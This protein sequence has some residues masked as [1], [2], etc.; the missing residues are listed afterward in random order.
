M[1]NAS[2]RPP[3]LANLEGPLANEEDVLHAFLDGLT[4]ASVAE[5]DWRKLAQLAERDGRTAELAFA[6]ETIA[7]GKRIKTYAPAL[8]AEFLYRAAVYFSTSLGDDFGARNFLERAVAI[9][10]GH[11]R[12]LRMLV[13]QLEDA[14]DLRR[15]AD[16]HLTLAKQGKSEAGASSL[17]RA[18][19]ILLEREEDAERAIAALQELVRWEPMDADARKQL[20]ELYGRAGRLKDLAKLAEQVVTTVGVEA[21]DV[22]LAREQLVALYGGP[23]REPEKA[24]PHLEAILAVDPS[25]GEALAVAEHLL[26]VRATAG[27]AAAALRSAAG[28]RGDM[29][30]QLRYLLV[31][32]EYARGAK[33]KEVLGQIGAIK[34]GHLS[35][36]RGALEAYEAA[37]L[38]DPTDDALRVHYKHI[39]SGLGAHGD[40]AKTMLRVAPSV[41][42]QDARSRIGVD[43]GELL[44]AAGDLRRAKASFS[45]ALTASTADPLTA[46]RAAIGLDTIAQAENDPKGRVAA[47]ERIVQL[48]NDPDLAEAATL[49]LAEIAGYVGDDAR[50]I[51]ANKR[52]LETGHR[53]LALASLVPL[54]DRAG[55]YAELVPILDELSREEAD[56]GAAESLAVRA[57]SLIGGELGDPEKAIS[58]WA[59]ILARF[60]PSPATLDAYEAILAAHGN[61][62]DLANV[63]ELKAVHA[64]PEGRPEVLLKL[65]R[66][67]LGTLEDDL[68]AADAYRHALESDL[69][70]TTRNELE[71]MLDST[72][73]RYLA[74][75]VLEPYYRHAENP[76]ALLRTLRIR[77]EDAA[78][79]DQRIEAAEE[80]IAMLHDDVSGAQV[81]FLRVRLRIAADV[82]DPPEIASWM[83]A[84]ESAFARK[85]DLAEARARTLANAIDVENLRPEAVDVVAA[86]ASAFEEA[87]LYGESA[88]MLRYLLPLEARLPRAHLGGPDLL[89][90]IDGLLQ[91]HGG[92]PERIAVYREALERES[93]LQGKLRLLRT[94]A[95]IEQYE[96]RDAKRASTTLEEAFELAPQDD[97][98]YAMLRDLYVSVSADRS[99]AHL[100][101]R[102]LVQGTELQQRDAHRELALVSVR[103]GKPDEASAHLGALLDYPNLDAEELTAAETVSS[104]IE[105]PGLRQR[106]L[107][108]RIEAASPGERAM[109]RV[110]LGASYLRTG[111][112]EL[113][114]RSL[115]NALSEALETDSDP[116]AITAAEA[117]L[118]IEA[119]DDATA[120]TLALLY[121]RNG[122][123]ARAVPLLEGV[124]ERATDPEAIADRD[125]E[126]SELFEEELG[127]LGKAFEASKRA[128]QGSP[129]RP[130]ALA[131]FERLAMQA[132]A[133]NDFA[134]TVEAHAPSVDREL[135]LGARY[136]LSRAR[137]LA[138]IDSDR[139]RARETLKAFLSHAEAERSEPVLEA[140]SLFE[141]L[142]A[143]LHEVDDDAAR[144]ELRWLKQ[145]RIDRK[146]GAAKLELLLDWA[147][148]EES[149]AEHA[150]ALG[151]YGQVL[152][153]YPAHLDALA[154]AART[155]LA[156]G[157]LDRALEC[158]GALRAAADDTVLLPLR[159]FEHALARALLEGRGA[160]GDVLTIAR[161][162]LAADPT[163]DDAFALLRVLS[164]GD[165]W[166]K[167]VLAI[168]E[169]ARASLSA[170][171]D[172]RF[173]ARAQALRT[174]C[175]TIIDLDKTLDA[176]RRKA[177]WEELLV[178]A[179][180]DEEALPIA[181]EA[182]HADPSDERLWDRI[183]DL[184]S[185]LRTPDPVAEAYHA[186]LRAESSRD[187]LALLGERAVRFYEE[188]YEEA[189]KREPL[190]ELLFERLPDE[191]WVFE[192]LKLL[193][194]AEERWSELFSI[195]DRAI[196]RA[197]GDA[198]LALLEDAAHTA[199][200]FAKD[201]P[202]AIAYFEELDRRK[203]GSTKTEGALERLYERHGRNAELVTLLVRQRDRATDADKVLGL[204]LRAADV[205]LAS[206]DLARASEVLA[207][208]AT[209]LHDDVR[210]RLETILTFSDSNTT[211]PLEVDEGSAR[212]RT[213]ARVRISV[214]RWLSAHYASNKDVVG[215]LARVL[216]VELRES[217]PDDATASD[218][219][220]HERL[221]RLYEQ[222]GAFESAL[223]HRV[224]LLLLDPTSDDYRSA[225]E[226]V[227]DRLEKQATYADALEQAAALDISIDV[228][229]RYL[230][231]A[232]KTY[233]A[234]GSDRATE[235]GLRVARNVEVDPAQR[236]EACV[237]IEAA[238]QQHQQQGGHSEVLLELL[239]LDASL[240][241]DGSRRLEVLSKAALLAEQRKEWAR[242]ASSWELRLAARP[243]DRE[244]LEHLA[245]LYERLEQAADLVRIL[246]L[247]LSL[248]L[249]DKAAQRRDAERAA[250][251]LEAPLGEHRRALALW[252]SIE[253][254]F[255][256]TFESAR[257]LARLYARDEDGAAY[258][259]AMQR[260][261]AAANGGGADEGN[262]ERAD[263]LSE[264]AVAE[265]TWANKRAN[266]LAHF[267]KALDISPAQPTARKWLHSLLEDAELR[268]G[269]LALLLRSHRTLGEN[270]EVLAL[271]EHR[272]AVAQSDDDKF[273]IFCDAMVLAEAYGDDQPEALVYA[274]R[275]LFLAPWHED[276]ERELLRLAAS[277]NALAEASQTLDTIIKTR[278]GLTD[279]ED[280]P[281]RMRVS[282]GNVLLDH[283]DAAG[284]AF[285]SFEKAYAD[286]PQLR[287]AAT[288]LLRAAAARNRY[289][290]VVD[291]LMRWQGDDGALDR[292]LLALAETAV[293]DRKELATA[294]ASVL[295][296]QNALDDARA[297]ALSLAT[298][299][300][301]ELASATVDAESLLER[302]IERSPPHVEIL[303]S[304][305][306]RL[307]RERPS[308]KLVEGLWA[309][310]HLKGGS[311]DLLQ[312]AV[313]AS[314]ALGDPDL[315]ILSLDHA[316]EGGKALDQRGDQGAP[317]LRW[318]RL[319]AA[320]TLEA[321]EDWH[322]LGSMLAMH[323]ELPYAAAERQELLLAASRVFLEHA[324]DADR[325][326]GLLLPEFQADPTNSAVRDRLTTLYETQGMGRA[327]VALLDR[328]IAHTDAISERALLRLKL[329]RTSEDL[330][331]WETSVGTLRATLAEDRSHGGTVAELARVL[332]ANARA[333]ELEEL[334]YAQSE[335]ARE[336]ARLD[337]AAAHLEHAADVAY[338]LLEDAPLALR[339]LERAIQFEVTEK[340]CDRVA[341]LAIE[342]GQPLVAIRY[343]QTLLGIVEGPARVPYLV[344][345]A[346][347]HA[348]VGAEQDAIGALE[349]ALWI[350]PGAK[351]ARSRIITLCRARGDA[352]RLAPLLYDAVAFADDD[353]EKVALL[354]E[355]ADLYAAKLDQAARAAELLERATQLAPE[356]RSLAMMLADALGQSG[357]RDGAL[358]ILAQLAS[359][360]GTRRPKERAPVHYYLARLHLHAGRDD[361]AFAEIETATRIDPTHLPA[362]SMLASIAKTMG[363]LDRAERAYR[364]V[365]NLLRRTSSEATP[366]TTY[367]C[368]VL[369][370][371]SDIARAQGENERA[372]EILETAFEAAAD[373]SFE[374]DQ[375]ERRFRS[376]GDTAL[377][378]RALRQRT[379]RGDPHGQAAHELATLLASESPTAAWQ[380]ALAALDRSPTVVAFHDSARA[381]AESQDRIQDLRTELHR[382]ADRA[383]RG[384]DTAT[385]A[386]LLARAA[387]I[388]ALHDPTTAAATLERARDLGLPPADV[389]PALANAYARLGVPEKHADILEA[390]L[391]VATD[392]AQKRELLRL[393]AEL[394]AKKAETL[395][396]AADHLAEVAKL[397][398]EDAALR[399]LRD[400]TD[401]F[402]DHAR[403][404]SQYDELARSHG[405]I[406]D[407]VDALGKLWSLD[408]SSFAPLEE[409]FELSKDAAPAL[410]EQLLRRCLE[411]GPSEATR[412]R[413]WAL[414]KLSELRASAGDISGSL[415]LLRDAARSEDP[416][417]ARAL[418][419][420]LG[421][422]ATAA[423]NLVLAVETYET[424]R[425]MDASDPEIWQPLAALYRTTQQRAKLLALLESVTPDIVA[426][427]ARAAL[428]LERVQ[429]L[430]AAGETS[431]DDLAAALEAVLEDDP[432]SAEAVQELSALYMKRSGSAGMF[433]F[434]E[435]QI[436]S[437][438]LRRD[439]T[440]VGRFAKQLA[441]GHIN[442]KNA[443][444]AARVLRDASEIATEDKDLLRL[445]LQCLVGVEGGERALVL[446]R[447]L[448]METGNAAADLSLELAQMREAEWDAA[449]AERALEIGFRAAP[450]NAQ[451][452]AKLET[453][454]RERGA[455]FKL[456]ELFVSASATEDSDDEK[457]DMLR[458]AATT[459]SELAGEPKRAAAVLKQAR[460]FRPMDL[461]LLEEHV[462]AL[463]AADDAAQAIAELSELM[464]SGDL[465]E[466]DRLVLVGR[467]A[468]LRAMC[469]QEAEAMDD[470]EAASTAGSSIETIADLAELAERLAMHAMDQGDSVAWRR[471]RLKGASLAE[472]VGDPDRARSA[473]EDLL[474]R[475]S[476]DEAVLFA[477][478][479]LE[480]RTEAWISALATYDRL[481][482]NLD[483]EA[484][485][486]VAIRIADLADRTEQG[487]YARDVLERAAASNP[488]R[489]D[490]HERL[491]QHYEGAGEWAYAAR[492]TTHLA[493][494]T[495]DVTEK[496][497]F[498]Q[499]SGAYLLDGGGTADEALVP[500]EEALAFA[501]T[502][503]DVVC[504]LADAYTMADR[505]ND[506]GALLQ[507]TIAAQKGRRTRELGALHH[508]MARVAQAAG[509]GAQEL[510]ALST[511]L[512]MDPQNGTAAAELAQLALDTGNFEVASRALRAVTLLKQPGPMSRAQAYEYLGEIAYQQGDPKKAMVMLKRALDEEPHLERAQALLAALR[513]K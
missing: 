419:E 167:D 77:A 38:L 189:Q 188:W 289:P 284:R 459:Y 31:E 172:D 350:S 148:D 80:G 473:L 58:A 271:T 159:A 330:G 428:A 164:D 265:L 12:A 393:L 471:M 113:A 472:Q 11:E 9:S 499:R 426:P 372:I 493:T 73:H 260:A 341:E 274:T 137:A 48:E 332:R 403:L 168:L 275:A 6:Y 40:A 132:G 317:L 56:A 328:Q 233:A 161:N 130:S 98:T 125:E 27:R 1:A 251:Q 412:V 511:A 70:F 442:E 357:N 155:A 255:G 13:T 387:D 276:V 502:D 245:P 169:T 474:S 377:L 109:L 120:A 263:L 133:Q 303:W 4:A 384:H 47:L 268:S 211:F 129:A 92:V 470:L 355:S 68:R 339:R 135:A 145:W 283:L 400:A 418:Y 119:D 179:A 205:A 247:R 479:G 8:A 95:R 293:V 121:R 336:D 117:L 282:L 65:A 308:R 185:T 180:S 497:A 342:I 141:D 257:A 5:D 266:A 299:R 66:L 490:L 248:P 34:E 437:A 163:D 416:D 60:G 305:L 122:Q 127:D 165:A 374:A 198:A 192:N 123:S 143:G 118:H 334:L 296:D 312:E 410:A 85:G 456:A 417:N 54:L 212:T 64:S 311:A 509:D 191:S 243:S 396:S 178:H 181:I 106:V 21:D 55:A 190:L 37:F 451:L 149:A 443:E 273:E 139:A 478:A 288:G 404:V 383:E 84:L 475:D 252:R 223:P 214:A 501:P 469:G 62:A 50:A 310:S 294:A 83:R 487:S 345:L 162:I 321:R 90:R 24:L 94:I 378:V 503:L 444:L 25:N 101:E 381:I 74:A 232:C 16:V 432:T 186:A 285:D 250:Q 460:S 323:A 57:A 318:T 481:A 295:L 194:D 195:F 147:R 438:K 397:G 322:A 463:V 142:I 207:R 22:L 2:Q 430:R 320:S 100:L 204:S 346:D 290:V 292:E 436:D 343:L 379:E 368:D 79:D 468:Q 230:I 277:T 406:E 480:E 256:P 174:I 366:S 280:W 449:G 373:N 42:D 513:E 239:E 510:Q 110:S 272:L 46:L 324:L 208:V 297:L 39:A 82:G 398:L 391:G 226:N 351:D 237:L 262:F 184:A 466:S 20:A 465:A 72:R 213:Q 506:A 261:A 96:G 153:A 33:R 136:S 152:D 440:T 464:D 500:L 489:R 89:T 241:Q 457:V 435:R 349:E 200:D 367:L 157:E 234:H 415:A 87:G 193:L 331:E 325:A 144:S 496:V 104:S 30:G 363:K 108:L 301:F 371:L 242:A 335:F 138:S 238:L 477:L 75:R 401:R 424:L 35:D 508:R 187:Q 439:T 10:P 166:R 177:L 259:E 354:R 114:Q 313:L 18:V 14:G 482:A 309:L 156:H 71:A 78:S 425:E 402:S 63:L 405:T 115:R 182:A 414:D 126:L 216:E 227:S 240:E 448:R 433:E 327:L 344:R 225:L 361:E 356:D 434:L 53:P 32:L 44:V 380:F 427:E 107:N 441:L 450:E 291:V 507:H 300:W 124:R 173:P 206:G 447:L 408:S 358:A 112:R 67:A 392:D 413:A 360:F 196:A 26:T 302:L 224:A 41:K 298:V 59:E 140:I 254:N 376:A 369:L 258:C 151:I 394:R 246:E 176:S 306:V 97:E 495:D 199:K 36:L 116:L 375:L 19:E 219:E 421:K 76:A 175:R 183:E 279:N 492:V 23:L 407:R 364:S 267:D 423:E 235:L 278:E 99:L 43:T 17:R 429:I 488:A 314:E 69:T 88:R 388:E 29:E 476:V 131:R 202:R 365:L 319:R 347:A 494:L 102:R 215:N 52:L 385:A 286:A 386:I 395:D 455:W 244:A 81:E 221:A 7:Q 150:V 158:Y 210:S 483:G 269:A 134:S 197:N 209:N 326:A 264:L 329:A 485:A 86:A 160:N 171:D 359:T 45:A 128:F 3:P 51:F 338:T 281:V 504:L 399:I 333:T 217:R 382:L 28:V 454:Y 270:L 249:G 203:P 446:E 461:A 420:R 287:A 15:V 352:T 445:L 220:Q 458:Q 467:R 498:L 307:R 340:R 105:E 337:L 91:M 411:L 154:G 222:A 462:A 431:E 229:A 315:V 231:L 409:G 512:D 353:Q 304:E 452:R 390:Q 253:E 362:T 93:D 505:A 61:A 491:L 111:D 146:E 422:R 218:R 201:P 348:S 370:E 484:L 389:L 49:A 103:L 486:G 316:L 228:R 170:S 453:V 236:L